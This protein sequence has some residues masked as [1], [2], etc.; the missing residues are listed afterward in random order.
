MTNVATIAS[1]NSTGSISSLPRCGQ[2]LRTNRSCRNRTTLRSGESSS[3]RRI[4]ATCDA[5]RRSAIGRASISV[6]RRRQTQI[7]S[8]WP[9]TDGGRTS[10]RGASTTKPSSASST[11]HSADREPGEAQRRLGAEAAHVQDERALASSQSARSK[12]PGSRSSQRP[13]VSSMSSAP[14]RTR[15]RR[16]GRP[17]RAARAP[18]AARRAARRPS[19][20]A[21]AS[22]TRSRRAGTRPSTGGSRRSPS[23]RST[24]TPAAA[25]ASR[26]T[27][28]IPADESTPITAMPAA[29]G[30]HGDPAGADRELD[31]RA[32]PSARASST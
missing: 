6:N 8:S 4:R 11:R 30:R 9:P 28:S 12:M 14:A 25:A 16:G 5:A 2:L 22:G 1:V 32:R 18:P 27:S 24:S 29:R 19:P 3:T 7:E 21:G 17:A 10:R 23:R 31:D 13:C 26:A 15:R 20:C